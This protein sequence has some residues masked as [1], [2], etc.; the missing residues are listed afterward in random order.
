MNKISI[1]LCGESYEKIEACMKREGAK[2][3]GDYVKGLLNLGLKVEETNK[4]IHKDMNK[5]FK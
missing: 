1:T 2:S 4:V 5:K 3:I